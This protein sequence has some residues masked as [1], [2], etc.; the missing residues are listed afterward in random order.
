[1]KRWI[2]RSMLAFALQSNFTFA[3]DGFYKADVRCDWEGGCSLAGESVAVQWDVAPEDVGRSG[4]I[5]VAARVNNEEVHYYTANGWATTHHNAYNFFDTFKK[6]PAQHSVALMQWGSFGGGESGPTVC[7]QMTQKGIGQAEI[8]LG[9]GAVQ[10]DAEEFLENYQSIAVPDKP[11][12]HF[13]LVFAFQDG[14]NNRKYSQVLTLTCPPEKR[15]PKW[16]SDAPG[17]VHIGHPE[18]DYQPESDYGGGN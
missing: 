2:L 8:W 13:R 1:M 12:E 9:Y 11:E 5:Y 7:G 4:A 3:N 16:P 6:L 17:V 18:R 10:D 15:R 14:R